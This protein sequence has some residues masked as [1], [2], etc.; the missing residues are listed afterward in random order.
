MSLIAGLLFELFCV[1][2]AKKD[3]ISL[4]PEVHLHLKVNT[5]YFSNFQ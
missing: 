5:L 3:I 1:D 4:N 2:N